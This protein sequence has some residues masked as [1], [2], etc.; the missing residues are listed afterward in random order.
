M[1]FDALKEAFDWVVSHWAFCAFIIGI[2]FEVPKWK[3]KPFTLLFKWIGKCINRPV[4]DEVIAVKEQAKNMA[5]EIESMKTE[6]SEL[7]KDV[8][9]NEIDI[10]RTTVLDFANSCRNGVRHTHEEFNHIIELNDKYMALLEKRDIKNGVYEAGYA[11]I[12]EINEK[13]QREN[14]YLA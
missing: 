4:M 3:F 9:M 1:N 10:I 5:S 13:C 12:I 7:A 2:V 6:I 8:D 11:Y 14:S